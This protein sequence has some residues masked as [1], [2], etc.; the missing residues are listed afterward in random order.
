MANIVT[1]DARIMKAMIQGILFRR[2]PRLALMRDLILD[3][4]RLEDEGPGSAGVGAVRPVW[5]PSAGGSAALEIPRGDG[6]R[7]S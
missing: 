4:D 3:D 5:P 6:E 2:P 7:A 1:V